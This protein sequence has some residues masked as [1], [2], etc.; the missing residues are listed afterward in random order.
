MTQASDYVRHDILVKKLEAYGISSC[1]MTQ[2]SDC[3]RHAILVKK[4]EAYGI[5]ITIP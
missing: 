5:S 3:V 4:L 1:D 2:V